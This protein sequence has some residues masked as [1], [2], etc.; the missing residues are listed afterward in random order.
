MM[1]ASD[2]GHRYGNFPNYYAFHPPDNRLRVL[3]R[4]NISSYIR[5]GLA[6]ASASAKSS[7]GRAV[8]DDDDDDNAADDAA[9]ASSSARKKPRHQPPEGRGRPTKAMS[10]TGRGDVV[11]YC[12]L[13]C[14]AGELTMAMARSLAEECAS[15]DDEGGGGG[16]GG[17]EKGGEISIDLADDVSE[18]NIR[19]QCLGLD[20]DPAL[21]ERAAAKFSTHAP[22]SPSPHAT[23]ESTKGS[24]RGSTRAAFEVCDLCSESEHNGACSSFFAGGGIVAG[25][26]DDGDDGCRPDRA[27]RPL[28]H[29]TTIFSTTMWI[30]VHGGDDG[31]REFLERACGWTR[32]YLLIEP[33]PSGW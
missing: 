27:P 8:D 16:G 33:Q 4:A 28:F 18:G 30:H 23:S 9:S 32:R 19:V 10:R 14:N 21:I 3:E 26:N 20:L 13:G 11:Y 31:L 5:D 25:G 29:L 15:D 22:P 24:R 17:E 2:Q 1:D 7:G 6:S 12:D